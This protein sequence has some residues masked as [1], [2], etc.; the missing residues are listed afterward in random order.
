MR[1]WPLLLILAWTT[2]NTSAETLLIAYANTHLGFEQQLRRFE[3]DSGVK[4]TFIHTNTTAMRVEMLRR[5]S[6]RT[7]PDAVILAADNLAL[8]TLSFS[9]IPKEFLSPLLSERVLSLGRRGDTLYGIPIIGGNHLMLYYNKSLL[10]APKAALEDYVPER[11]AGRQPVRPIVWP[12]ASMYWF[13]P[14][15]LAFDGDPLRPV[16]VRMDSPEMVRALG[17]YV[18]LGHSLDL[19]AQC[20]YECALAAFMDGK[21]ASLIDGEWSM[22]RLL[23]QWGDKLGIASLPTVEGVP[24]RAVCSAQ[25]LAFPNLSLRGE[26]RVALEKFARFVQSDAFQTAVWKELHAIPV[27]ADAVKAV[28]ASDD[29]LLKFAVAGFESAR[30]MPVD[31]RMPV[32]WEALLK[33]YERHAEGQYDA[34]KSAA[35]MQQLV[36][37]SL[38]SALR[39]AP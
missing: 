32:I 21:A 9:R 22:G 33:G 24:L 12:H 20:D 17:K 36:D 29:E 8:E 5:A 3:Q 14:F 6:A 35:Y 7:L 39:R 18:K 23:S 15:A 27:N 31:P 13:L 19:G 4:L 28:M 16:E 10:P 26:K 34:A 25:V 37:K 1:T 2:V 11:G 30:P 38:N